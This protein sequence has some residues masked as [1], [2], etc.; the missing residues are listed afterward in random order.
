[1]QTLGFLTIKLF[2]RTQQTDAHGRMYGSW[3]TLFN[4]MM[5][6]E[7]V[8]NAIKGFIEMNPWIQASNT[9]LDIHFITK[10]HFY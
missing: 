1:M 10:E 4:R 6:R 7:D 8:E 9:Q 3:R 2:I 5:E